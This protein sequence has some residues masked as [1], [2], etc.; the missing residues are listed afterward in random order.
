MKRLW[1]FSDGLAIAVL[2]G[3]ALI[4]CW[5]VWA[6]I[7]ALALRNDESSYILLAPFVA[8]WLAWLRRGRLRFCHTRPSPFGV[9]L[10]A[11]GWGAMFVGHGRAIDL[12]RDFGALL[13]AAGAV[14]AV[15]GFGVFVRFAAVWGALLFLIPVPGRIRHVIAVPLQQV[16]ADVTAKL[17][18]LFSVPTEQHGNMLGGNGVEVAIAEACNGMRMVAAIGLVAYAFVFSFP[19]RSWARILLLGI[20]PLV[21]ILV[22]VIRLVPTTILYGYS[23]TTVATAFHDLAGWAVLGLAI[24]LMWLVLWL[25]RFLELPIAAYRVRGEA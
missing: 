8:A 19:M 11:I 12:F 10:I 3:L 17:L 14:L 6:D 24:G 5:A 15:T 25:L 2:L 23:S 20:S 13:V 18:N 4:A 22:N 9:V 16:S 21:A 1:T 7:F